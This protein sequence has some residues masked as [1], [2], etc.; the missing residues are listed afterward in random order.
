[1]PSSKKKK[2]TVP[3]VSMAGLIRYYE[4]EKEKVKISPTVLITI[5]IA[6]IAGVILASVLIPPP[7]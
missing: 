1:M 2:E 6:L 3:L 7:V 4:E 5:G